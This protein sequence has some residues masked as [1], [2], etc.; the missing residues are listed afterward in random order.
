MSFKSVLTVLTDTAF[1]ADTLEAAIAFSLLHDAHLDVLCLGVDRSQSSYA[2]GSLTAFALTQTLELAREDAHSL[3][4]IAEQF[5]GAS[6]LRYGI[7]STPCALPD[8]G[9]LVAQHAQFADMVI[10]ARPY[11]MNR[12]LEMETT[13]E[14]ALFDASTPAW[15]VPEQNPALTC[16]NIIT[17]AW[18]QSPEA[19]RAAKAALPFLKLAEKVHVVIIDPPTH[20]PNR[21]DPGGMLSQFLARHG[22]TVEV[23]VLSKTLPRVS[24]V[25][26]RSAVECGS[27]LIVMGAYGHSRLRESILGGATRHMLEQSQLPVFMTH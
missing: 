21:S 19:M 8:V 15:V 23:D 17:L 10:L 12:G 5:L 16:P 6:G 9:R 7:E 2:Y 24:D 26:S 25:L 22:V 11:G 14:A 1:A 4:Q 13:I 18:N 27:D 20:G 3:A